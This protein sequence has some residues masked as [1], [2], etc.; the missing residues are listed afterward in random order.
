[1]SQDWV[2]YVVRKG[3]TVSGLA[4]R[5]GA[6]VA[7]VWN[8]PKNAELKARRANPDVLSPS[9]LLWLPPEKTPIPLPIAPGDHASVRI[10]LPRFTVRLALLDDAG[11][12]IAG[13]PY[14]V[15]GGRVPPP[16]QTDGAGVAVFETWVTSRSVVVRLPARNHEFTVFVGALDPV[17]T[18]SGAVGRLRNLGWYFDEDR[19]EEAE[20]LYFRGVLF[21]F[22]AQ[23]RLEE[24]GEL[25]EPTQKKLAELAGGD[26]EFADG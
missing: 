16:G 19:G 24:T 7:E 21:Q 8:H 18:R 1:M 20:A 17:A 12:P 11:K 14:E 13:E 15:E 22:Q 9:D 2:P 5:R 4:Y 26:G 6:T 25:D 10:D 3:D 23:H